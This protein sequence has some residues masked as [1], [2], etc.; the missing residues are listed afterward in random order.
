MLIEIFSHFNFNLN[1]LY[2]PICQIIEIYSLTRIMKKQKYK[3][4]TISTEEY[5]VTGM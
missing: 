5:I 4:Y 3:N 2:F 1:S